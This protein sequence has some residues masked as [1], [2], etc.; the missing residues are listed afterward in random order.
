MPSPNCKNPRR[1]KQRRSAPLTQSPREFGLWR[2]PQ[3]C[4]IRINFASWPDTGSRDMAERLG[5]GRYRHE[6]RARFGWRRGRSARHAES[7]FTCTRARRDCFQMKGDKRRDGENI[8][9]SRWKNSRAIGIVARYGSTKSYPGGTLKSTV[10]KFPEIA[11]GFIDAPGIGLRR[12]DTS[13]QPLT[14]SA[15]IWEWPPNVCSTAASHD[16]GRLVREAG[17]VSSSISV[18]ADHPL[19][20]DDRLRIA[21][22]TGRHQEL[23]NGSVPMASCAA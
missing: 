6:E 22:E 17:S 18:G 15:R 9:C 14:A 20:V 21:V 13:S 7:R 2:E 23:C 16:D 10:A 1:Q 5:S 4:R 19:G 8:A 3:C 12:R 11:H